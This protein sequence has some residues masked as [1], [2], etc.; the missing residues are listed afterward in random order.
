MSRRW[1]N[2]DLNP[3]RDI[4]VKHLKELIEVAGPDTVVHFKDLEIRGVACHPSEVKGPGYL[5]ACMDEY[6]EYNLWQTWRTHLEI[7]PKLDLGA[8]L[9]P[10]PVDGLAVPQLVVPAPRK[11]FGRMARLMAGCPDSDLLMFGV[12]GT[13]GKTTTTR[14]VAH[15]M[16]CL[17]ISCGSIGTLGVF[18]NERIDQPGTYTTPLAPQLYGHLRE[19]KE[20]GAR[21]VAMEV[22][23]HALALDR[24]AGLTFSGAVLT[25]IERDHLDFHGTTQAYAEAKKRLFSLVR[26]DGWSILNRHCPYWEPFARESSGRVATF[27]SAGSG[28]D[29]EAQDLELQP[30]QSIFTV[31]YQGRRVPFVS[32]LAGGFQ[33]ENA[34]GAIALLAS[35]GHD[36]EAL[37]AALESFDPVHGRMEQIPLPNGC[38]ALV[39]YA[40]NPDGL[41]HLLEACRP[42]CQARLHLVF[43]CGGDRD[44]GKRPL[45]GDIANRL[46]DVCWITSDNPRTEDPDRIIDDILS[47]IE[48]GQGTFHRIPDRR[49]A[50]LEAYKNTRPGDILVVAGKGHEDYQIVGLTKHPFSDQAVLRD[51]G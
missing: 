21:A 43:G 7:L 25:N 13:N 47:G 33:V 49:Q 30:R 16:E 8:L 32:R 24:I 42:F 5:F 4:L 38:T 22:S 17:G 10:E 12:T 50:I 46:A 41:Q 45:M 18:L 19:L 26:P 23:S 39:D 11:A 36:L 44:K 48:T 37:A 40:H 20:A 27:G 1:L 2:T 35:M 34:M 3:F 28:A 9:V 14:M 51:L 29:F 15:M 6:L 31:A